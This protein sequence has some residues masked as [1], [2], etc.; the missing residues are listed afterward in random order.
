VFLE[1]R[2]CHNKTGT[3]LEGIANWGVEKQTLTE[4]EILNNARE[5]V[6]WYVANGC[7]SIRTHVD[8][9]LPS[10]I[11]LK[12]LLRLR[13]EIKDTVD[14]QIV[15]FPQDGIFTDPAFAGLMERAVE[16]GADVVGGIPHNEFTRE[17]GV[18]DVEFAFNLAE[19]KGLRIDI[20]CDETGDAQSRFVE[21]MAK[22]T[23]RRGLQ[24]RVTASHTTAMHNYDNDYA[25]KLL[26]ILKR[27]DMQ[28]VTNPF[29]NSVLQNR[30]DGYPRRRGHTRV[31]QLLARGVN[32]GIGHD[33]IMDPW[34]PLGRA[35]LLQAANLFLHY[36]HFSGFDQVNTLFDL[37][38]VNNARILGLTDYGIAVGK[39]ATLALLDAKDEAE[40]IRLESPCRAVISR[41]RVVART[42]PAQTTVQLCGADKSVD[43]KRS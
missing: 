32:V 37:V 12:A 27:A 17:D 18:A 6:R 21:V 14:L 39:P 15:A 10:L 2:S 31:D 20:H 13:E 25:F 30:N 7:L 5:A 3:L 35:S 29:D 19:K 28:M 22:E 42:Q 26:G 36:G 11:N 40:A 38:T 43:F 8:T 1:G 24:G 34:Y 33:S 16:M 9:T 23:I 4:E 41:G